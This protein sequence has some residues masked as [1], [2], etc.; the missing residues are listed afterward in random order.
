MN[1]TSAA[2][3]RIQPSPTI[4]VTNKAAELK[5]QGRDIIGLG[6]GEPDFDTPTHIADAGVDAIRNGFTRYTAVEGIPELKDAIIAKF[7]RDNKL[8][9]TLDEVMV[10]NGSKQIMYDALMASVNTGDEVIIPTPGWISYADQA[11]V[12]GATPVFVDVE[13]HTYLIDPERIEAAIAEAKAD[14]ARMK[15]RISRRITG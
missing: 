15:M 9:Y 13:E 10:S 1:R 14:S 2:I 11:T 3:N 5:R 8:D 4:A 7:K 6:A 12:A